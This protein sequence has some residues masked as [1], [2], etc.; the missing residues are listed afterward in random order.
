MFGF[1]GPNGAGKTTTMNIITGYI[2]QTS[3]D[4]L[5]D[6]KPRNLHSKLKIGYM[7]ENAPLYEYLTVYEYINFTSELKG[8]SRNKRKLENEE[9]IKN[10]N[11]TKVRNKLIKTL[12]RGYKQRVSLAGALIGKPDILILDEPTIGLDPEQVIEIR[13]LIKS[14]GKNHTI[15]ISSH[16]LSEVSNTCDKVIIINNGKIMKIDSIKNIE[17]SGSLE[18]EFL[19]TV[20]GKNDENSKKKGEKN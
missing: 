13:S 2:N 6:N 11:L 17:K 5:I 20:K 12:S 10:L 8:I 18:E 3:G 19:R 7:P 4:V 16:I 15:L 14:L 1:L 9:I